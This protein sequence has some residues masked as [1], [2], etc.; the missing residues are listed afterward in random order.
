MLTREYGNE[1]CYTDATDFLRFN[2]E[3]W[4]ES[5][6][7]PVGAMEEFLDL[8]LQDAIGEVES[9]LNALIALGEKAENILAGGKKYESSLSGDPLNAFQKISIGFGLQNLCHEAQGY[10]ICH[11]GTPAA[12]PMLEIKVSDLDKDEFLLNTPGCYL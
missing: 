6:Q 3:Y 11:L 7:Q 4:M 2:G 10:E 8:Q 5:K 9:A 1:L 12:K